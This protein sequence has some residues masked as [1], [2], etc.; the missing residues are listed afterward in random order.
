MHSYQPPEVVENPGSLTTH[1]IDP[2]KPGLPHKLPC[3]SVQ[4]VESR[5]WIFKHVL[6]LWQLMLR[7]VNSKILT[8]DPNNSYGTKTIRAPRKKKPCKNE[9]HQHCSFP[10]S[11]S[12]SNP[13][14]GGTHCAPKNPAVQMFQGKH[15]KKAASRNRTNWGFKMACLKFTPPSFDSFPQQCFFPQ[16]NLWQTDQTPR[17][18]GPTGPDRS[19]ITPFKKNLSPRLLR[20]VFSAEPWQASIRRAPWPSVSQLALSW[21]RSIGELASGSTFLG[22]LLWKQMVWATLVRPQETSSQS[23]KSNQISAVCQNARKM[24]PDL[25]QLSRKKTSYRLPTIV[26]WTVNLVIETPQLTHCRVRS[27]R[28]FGWIRSGE[29][30]SIHSSSTGRAQVQFPFATI[31]SNEIGADLR[32]MCLVQ[33]DGCMWQSKCVRFFGGAIWPVE[34]GRLF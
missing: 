17:N 16:I 3:R 18:H 1:R 11:I 6:T 15:S 8:S 13:S 31:W 29:T 30:S 10:T 22:Q 4:V 5:S 25:S 28:C 14:A 27:S 24:A 20:G 33:M 19:F 34:F 9:N 26:R 12:N 21:R 7:L 32:H 2:Q 23:P